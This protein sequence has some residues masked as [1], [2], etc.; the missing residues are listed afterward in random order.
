MSLTDRGQEEV[1]GR[2]IVLLF[3]INYLFIQQV[4]TQTVAVCRLF[5][6]FCLVACF[7]FSDTGDEAYGLVHARQVL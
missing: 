2:D 7:A 3:G 1:W 6:R 4:F 5:V